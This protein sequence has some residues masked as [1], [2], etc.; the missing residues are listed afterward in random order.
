MMPSSCYAGTMQF[1]SSPEE[2][3]QN[4]LAH[5]EVPQPSTSTNI[6]MVRPPE[7]FK[8]SSTGM[9]NDPKLKSS[10]S[11]TVNSRVQQFLNRDGE[12]GIGRGK[13]RTY[14]SKQI[15]NEM[16][17]NGGNRIIQYKASSNKRRFT[18]KYIQRAS[19]VEEGILILEKPYL[20]RKLPCLKGG[21]S[22]Q[23]TAMEKMNNDAEKGYITPIYQ[24]KKRQRIG[25]SIERRLA[26][27]R[28]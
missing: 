4:V 8:T 13:K 28:K 12:R 26:P 23:S 24:I 5:V 3:S 6:Q 11:E 20:P 27:F 21:E 9:S 10:V 7:V 18:K 17:M 14:F 25:V 1:Y 16:K 19:T 15:A 22:S 2:N